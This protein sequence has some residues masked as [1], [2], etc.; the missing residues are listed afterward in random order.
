MNAKNQINSVTK[1]GEWAITANGLL[2]L[3]TQDRELA[4]SK[5][6]ELANHEA[7]EIRDYLCIYFNQRHPM[8]IERETHLFT[9]KERYFV[10]LP[11]SI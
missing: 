1:S 3:M 9:L 2:N 7:N 4:Q 8:K 6:K 5:I 11:R 10:M